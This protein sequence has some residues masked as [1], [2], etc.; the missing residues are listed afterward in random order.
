[1]LFLMFPVDTRGVL[2]GRLQ[3]PVEVLGIS[4]PPEGLYLP[5]FRS[6]LVGFSFLVLCLGLEPW[7]IGCFS[8]DYSDYCTE[9]AAELLLTSDNVAKKLTEVAASV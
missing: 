2:Y 7:S 1:M 9:Q 5:L 6:E 8:P 4:L 3:Q